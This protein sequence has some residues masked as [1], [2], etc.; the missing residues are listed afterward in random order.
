M[1]LKKGKS[2]KVVSQNI[3]EFHHGRTYQRTLAKHGRSVANKQAIAAALEQ[4]RR[5][6]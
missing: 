3:S 4:R 6:R 1:P 2:D 5:S